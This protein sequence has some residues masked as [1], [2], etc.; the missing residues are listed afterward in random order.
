MEYQKIMNLLDNTPN[1]PPRFITKYWVEINDG[2]YGVYIT[3]SQIKFKTS[4]IRS[5]LCDYRDAF[6]LV[7]G[8]ITVINTGTAAAPNNRNK[9]VIFK[10]CAPFTDYIREI[11]NKEIYHA[12]DIDV[13]MAIYNLIEYSDNYLKASGNLWQYYTDESLINNNAVI[14][15]VPDD[16]DNASFKYKQKI[17]GQTGNDGTK[18]VRITVTLKYLSSFSRTLEMPLIKCEINIFLTWSEEC[19]IVTGD[20]GGE[21]RK[22]AITDTKLYVPVVTLSAQDNEKLLQQLKA[23]FKRTINWNKYQSKPTLQTRN[24]YY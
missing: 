12:K 14:I 11:N 17:T 3:G 4:M 18:D 1:Q 9:K 23:G 22:F 24:Q 19:I 15:D 2:S 5:S 20:Y 8:T 10:N 6:V 16:S 21:K 7:K 13:V